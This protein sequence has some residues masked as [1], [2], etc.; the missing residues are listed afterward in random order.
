MVRIQAEN[1]ISRAGAPRRREGWRILPA[2]N[3]RVPGLNA[4]LPTEAQWEYAC[5]AGRSRPFWFGDN[6]TSDQVNYD[7]N[8]PYA[9]GVNGECRQRTVDVKAL[10]SNGWGLYQMHGNVWEWCADWLGD[11]PR[12]AVVDPPGPDEGRKRVL[13]GG[14]WIGSGRDCRSA[15]RDGR[16][17]GHRLGSFGFRLARGSS[18]P[19]GGRV[20][21]T[22]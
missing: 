7:G 20:R 2:L 18:P 16:G 17:P 12:G 22:R 3:E 4:A 9:G 5:R 1:R 11:Y 8:Y 21:D 6:I 13:R 10:P 15:G 19:V 14:G